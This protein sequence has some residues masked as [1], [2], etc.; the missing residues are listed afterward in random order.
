MSAGLMSHEEGVEHEAAF[1]GS[2][3]DGLAWERAVWCALFGEEWVKGL[4]ELARRAAE[5]GIPVEAGSAPFL[6]SFHTHRWGWAPFPVPV[7]DRIVLLRSGHAGSW[8]GL[9]V[10]RTALGFG[11]EL[12]RLIEET[13]GLEASGKHPSIHV[14]EGAACR[15]PRLTDSERRWPTQEAWVRAF[16]FPG[17]ERFR[18]RIGIPSSWTELVQSLVDSGLFARPCPSFVP[19]GEREEASLAASDLLRAALAWDNHRTAYDGARQAISPIPSSRGNGPAVSG[20]RKIVFRVPAF[21][22]PSAG[23]VPLLSP[24]ALSAERSSREAA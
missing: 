22:K 5:R 7:G 9:W 3:R 17:N 11:D 18:R 4:E 13:P 10:L 6:R 1:L 19:S 16:L 23:G 24:S 15:L 14:E 21:A 8:R 12:R 2:A 20:I